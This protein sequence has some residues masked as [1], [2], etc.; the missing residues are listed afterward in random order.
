MAFWEGL[1]MTLAVQW[2]ARLHVSLSL[3]S[4]LGRKGLSLSTPHGASCAGFALLSEPP[5]GSRAAAD[6]MFLVPCEGWA[7]MV[8]PAE[9][10]PHTGPT[11][12]Q[13]GSGQLPLRVTARAPRENNAPTN[14]WPI[15]GMPP[16]Q[17][18]PCV[19]ENKQ[20]VSTG[21]GGGGLGK[22]VR[23]LRDMDFQLSDVTGM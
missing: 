16:P 14:S 7:V 18:H 23:A 3:L 5:P 17:T 22:E 11:L 9:A 20:V 6:E 13:G 2:S 15:P 12:P 4:C 1:P 10:N 19:A 21:K 8:V